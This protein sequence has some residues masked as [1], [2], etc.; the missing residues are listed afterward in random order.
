MF[1]NERLMIFS[2]TFDDFKCF[3]KIFYENLMF[4]LC[5]S[6]FFSAGLRSLRTL[7]RSLTF[8]QKGEGC[9]QKTHTD[10]TA[11]YE[12]ETECR[13]A[14]MEHCWSCCQLGAT[15]SWRV[16]CTVGGRRV[17]QSWCRVRCSGAVTQ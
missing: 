1:F 10:G 3:L 8:C 7:V 16:I 5:N 17:S 14:D 6:V 12:H 13:G 9:K 4:L 15:S 11:A 2:W